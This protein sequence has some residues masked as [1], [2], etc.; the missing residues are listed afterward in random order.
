M[1]RLL[2]AVCILALTVCAAGLSACEREKNDPLEEV[3]IGS[4]V[5]YE[6]RNRSIVYDADYST[7]LSERSFTTAD[8]TVVSIDDIVL[9]YINL[10]SDD[11]K[12]ANAE[13]KELYMRLATSF[14]AE[15]TGLKTFWDKAGYE[16]SVDG[17]LVTVRITVTSGGGESE[18]KTEETVYVFDTATGLTAP[19]GE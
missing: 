15:M 17:D 5:R 6:D 7:E 14:R 18:E 8:G 19:A 1:K 10:R 9:P 13:I 16:T 2:C 12:A 3:T 11:A 4:E